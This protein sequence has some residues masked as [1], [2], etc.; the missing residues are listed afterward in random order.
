M[1]IQISEVHSEVFIANCANL[2]Q[3]VTEKQASGYE[4]TILT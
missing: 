3:K 4:P 2:K 1:K